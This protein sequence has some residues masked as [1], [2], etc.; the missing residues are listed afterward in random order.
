MKIFKRKLERRIESLEAE[1][2]LV[3]TVDT[4]GYSCHQT[5]KGYSLL[6][7]LVDDVKELNNKVKELTEVKK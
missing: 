1:L 4:E 7:N 3:Y 2:G 6:N 5:I